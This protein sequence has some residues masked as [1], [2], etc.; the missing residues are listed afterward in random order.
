ME[1]PHISVL[2]YNTEEGTPPL[3]SGCLSAPSWNP[4]DTLPNAEFKRKQSMEAA[5]PR[6][7]TEAGG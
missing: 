7:E 4:S 6:C 5:N 3:W 1:F 2:N